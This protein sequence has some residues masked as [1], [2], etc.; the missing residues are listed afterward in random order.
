MITL[1]MFAGKW[2]AVPYALS[3]LTSG[4]SFLILFH[5]IR[6]SPKAIYDSSVKLSKSRLARLM[7]CSRNAVDTYTKQLEALNL[8]VVEGKVG[9]VLSFKIN[10]EEVHLLSRFVSE[11]NDEGWEK[12]YEACIC[13]ENII[14]F[15]KLDADTCSKI[16]QVYKFP[17]CSEFEQ[18]ETNESETCSEI[19][20]V[21]EQLAQNL[22]RLMVTCSDF[23]QVEM[24]LAQK[25]SRFGL[26]CS[27]IQQVDANDS[28]LYGNNGNKIGQIGVLTCSE[29][30]QVE[31]E[32]CSKNEQVGQKPAQNLSTVKIYKDNNI[33]SYKDFK[34]NHDKG[35][36]LLDWALDR[37]LE[38]YDLLPDSEFENILSNPNFY[39]SSED[40]LLREVWRDLLGFQDTEENP[41]TDSFLVPVAVFR[42]LL[43]RVMEELG[44]QHPD[45]HVT[46]QQA[47]NMF[48]FDVDTSHEEPMYMITSRSIRNI[49]ILPPARQRKGKDRAI[50]RA[51]NLVFIECLEKIKDDELDLLSPAEYAI[52][53]LVDYVEDQKNKK[54]PN[55][56]ELTK[57]AYEELVRDIS[58]KSNLP[59][60]DLKTM[61]KDLPVKGNKVY[62]HLQQLIVD[63]VWQYNHE[64]N[65]SNYLEEIWKQKYGS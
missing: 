37:N 39:S 34:K 49:T 46:E 40:M 56:E 58:H 44:E 57:F 12:L 8:I 41:Q 55:P 19:E 47:K 42:E 13:G 36:F 2:G 18:V 32:T 33:R 62:L 1:N 64:H 51:K 60:D 10:W 35:G 53:L 63:K 59:V 22:S 38:N 9:S 52:L 48:G 21:V 29:F 20:Q 14:P 11:I 15:S 16:Q 26:T 5:I 61:W 65:E 50:E 43:F 45:F 28:V 3:A 23:E 17:T 7:H 31:G 27:K 25:L 24:L 54:I 4:N 30:E 6:N